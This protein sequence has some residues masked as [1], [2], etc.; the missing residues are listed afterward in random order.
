[1]KTTVLELLEGRET[2]QWMCVKMKFIGLHSGQ[3]N[4]GCIHIGEIDK[5][6]IC[7]VHKAGCLISPNL[8]S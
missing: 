7:S 2:A 5:H 3:S 1:M 4:N 6:G 8:E